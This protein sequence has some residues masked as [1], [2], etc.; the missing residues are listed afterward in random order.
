MCLTETWRAPDSGAFERYE[1][2]DWYTPYH[3]RG[4]VNGKPIIV[5]AS[6]SLSEIP[7]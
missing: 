5:R 6:I 4:F 2:G 1:Q 7:I 3:I